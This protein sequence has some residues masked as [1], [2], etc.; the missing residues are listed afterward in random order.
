[1]EALQVL[2]TYAYSEEVSRKPEALI[3]AGALE[4]L[5]RVPAAGALFD[6]SILL[7]SFTDGRGHPFYALL[8][9][10]APFEGPAF[11]LF[12]FPQPVSWRPPPCMLSF[13]YFQY[14]ETLLIILVSVAAAVL[15]I[16]GLLHRLKK[17]KETAPPEAVTVP[18][19][20][21]RQILEEN[22]PFYNALDEAGRNRFEARV[23]R[24]L[25]RTRITGVGTEVEPLDRVLVAASAIIPIFAFPDWEYINL[26]EVLLYPDAFNEEFAQEGEGRTTLGV[27]GTGPYQNL[28][29]LSR[30]ELRQGFQNRTG[31]R[32][33]AIHEFVHLVDKTDGA[34]D[35]IPEALLERGYV[36]PWLKM[37]RGYLQEL[38]RGKTDINPYGATNEAEFFAV[39]AEYFFE[40]PDLLEEKHPELYRMLSAIFLQEPGKD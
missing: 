17:G 20:E 31:K 34:V 14:M 21:E 7:G 5:F 18:A 9:V 35:G 29:I 28:M 36:Q 40:R 27:V 6:P 13:P 1:M 39:V 24:F 30:H 19:G 23:Q 32:N 22:V 15:L 10:P 11:L 3:R 2:R 4:A 38:M 8:R 12:T 33:T 26:K 25:G 37:I 16:A